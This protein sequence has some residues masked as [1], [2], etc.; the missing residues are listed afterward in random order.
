VTGITARVVLLGNILRA[1]GDFT[2]NQVACKI[3]LLSLAGS[4]LKG[5]D[6]L[7]PSFEMVARG[8]R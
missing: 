6:E 1:S 3:G 5:K 4:A 7:K 8:Q 2:L